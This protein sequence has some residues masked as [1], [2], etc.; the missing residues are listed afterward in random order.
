MR[1]AIDINEWP[2]DRSWDSQCLGMTTRIE[3]RPDCAQVLFAGDSHAIALM[4]LFKLFA[5]AV[6]STFAERTLHSCPP[7]RL[8]LLSE[9]SYA[10]LERFQ[11]GCK[12][13]RPDEALLLAERKFKGVVFAA[14]WSAYMFMLKDVK[15]AV[16][17]TIVEL[18]RQNVTVVLISEVPASLGFA[19]V[20]REK[21][22]LCR[23]LFATCAVLPC[24]RS[25]APSP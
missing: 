14:R 10:V 1:D 18:A 24:G 3:A 15:T 13:F 2:S 6:I 20:A 16:H 12:Q 19:Q 17:R 4:A 5:E 7:C 11:L 25:V 21:A 23:I 8:V 22:R 9:E